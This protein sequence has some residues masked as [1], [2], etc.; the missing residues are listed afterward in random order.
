M[1]AEGRN[2]QNFLIMNDLDFSTLPD[3]VKNDS[4]LMNLNINRMS[5]ADYTEPPF[6]NEQVSK[7]YLLFGKRPDQEEG[8]Q[9]APQ[10][11]YPAGPTITLKNLNMTGGSGASCCRKSICS[12]P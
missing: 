9:E 3:S 5:G 8:N 6:E 7:D 2:Y 1:K 4:D 10:G 12:C 11:S